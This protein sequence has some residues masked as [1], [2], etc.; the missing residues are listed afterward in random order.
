[1]ILSPDDIWECLET[2]LLLQLEG[3]GATDLVG[4]VHAANHHT[5][6]RSDLMPKI[7]VAPKANSTEVEK[8]CS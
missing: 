7:Y 6:Y 2:F 1:M 4:R 8:Y 5:I 3:G